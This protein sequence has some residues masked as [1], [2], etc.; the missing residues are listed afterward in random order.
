[1]TIPTTVALSYYQM[2]TKGVSFRSS[3]LNHYP[4][5]SLR[6]KHMEVGREHSGEDWTDILGWHQDAV[7]IAEDGWGDFPCSAESVSIWVKVGAKGR[8]GF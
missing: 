8:D 3:T 5:I 1:V 2:G 7:K 6:L 4:L